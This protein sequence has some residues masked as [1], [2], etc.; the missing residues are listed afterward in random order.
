M[1]DEQSTTKNRS[2]LINLGSIDT[3]ML[4]ESDKSYKIPLVL[5]LNVED[6]DFSFTESVNLNEMA[7]AIKKYE[8]FTIF[9]NIVRQE[10]DDIL[11]KEKFDNEFNFTRE[12]EMERIKN[13]NKQQSD[14]IGKTKSKW[15]KQG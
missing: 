9:A 14:Q 11:S 2:L 5:N 15:Y 6:K 8:N 12:S 7:Y 1:N 4:L 10:V 3:K 13:A